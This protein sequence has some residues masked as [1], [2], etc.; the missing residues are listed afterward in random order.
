MESWITRI[1]YAPI[2]D[3]KASNNKVIASL[4]SITSHYVPIPHSCSDAQSFW[5]CFLFFCLFFLHATPYLWHQL[6]ILQLQATDVSEYHL[7]KHNRVLMRRVAHRQKLRNQEP[8]R[9]CAREAERSKQR[10]PMDFLRCYLLHDSTPANSLL[11]PPSYAS[12]FLILRRDNLIGLFEWIVS[13]PQGVSIPVDKIRWND[14]GAN[15]AHLL[16]TLDSV[17]ESFTSVRLESGL[18]R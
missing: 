2:L 16:T 15:L 18:L 1:N 12:S 13:Y 14:N 5:I 3:C 6:I 10:E 17:A 11:L 7:K 4:S 9:L 8:G